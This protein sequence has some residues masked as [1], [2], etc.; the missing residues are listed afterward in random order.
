[1][2]PHL[3]KPPKIS[4]LKEFK[5]V[6]EIS[7]G[8]FGCCSTPLSVSALKAPRGWKWVRRS[9]HGP[10]QLLIGGRHISGALRGAQSHF[11][12]IQGFD[13]LTTGMSLRLRQPGLYRL[14][15]VEKPG[16]PPSLLPTSTPLSWWSN[17]SSTA[18][19]HSCG[20]ILSFFLCFLS[21]VL[22]SCY[23]TEVCSLH[24]EAQHP[25]KKER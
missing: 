4:S 6:A 17:Q 25:Q 21:F 10:L 9:Q 12:D 24:F 1:M 3:Q 15:R 16:G 7:A 13:P 14:S 2:F 23:F 8:W 19:S 22:L 18:M 20:H 5:E 11:I